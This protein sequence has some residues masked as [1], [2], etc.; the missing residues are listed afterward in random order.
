MRF[1]P[2]TF[3]R[4][5]MRQINEKERMPAMVYFHPWELDP[6]QPRITAPL[7][8]RVR[9]YTNLSTVEGKL[10]RLLTDFRFSTL[11]DVSGGLDVYRSKERNSEFRTQNSE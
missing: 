1:A 2:Y 9:H 3:T 8:S 11:T 6:D 4:W 5:A 10:S 7:R